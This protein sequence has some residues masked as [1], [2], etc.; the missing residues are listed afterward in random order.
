MTAKTIGLAW[1][2]PS[3]R[4]R[5]DARRPDGGADCNTV[6]GSTLCASGTVTGSSGAPTS[7]LSTTRI[8]A[9]AA[10]PAITTTTTTGHR[11]STSR[12][13]VVAGFPEPRWWR[14]VFGPSPVGVARI[15]N[16]EESDMEVPV[17]PVTHWQPPWVPVTA[18]VLA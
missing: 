17:Q 9:T 7:V 10:L 2:W 4:Q 13:S 8:R 18:S 3:A 14:G 1:P 11:F 5:S 12:T 6:T 15:I 16:K